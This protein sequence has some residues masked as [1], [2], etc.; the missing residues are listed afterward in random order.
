MQVERQLC[1]T[2]GLKS[3]NPRK[4]EVYNKLRRRISSMS[5]RQM[6]RQSMLTGPPCVRLRG[7]FCS[8]EAILEGHMDCFSSLPPREQGNLHPGPGQD[9]FRRRGVNKKGGNPKIL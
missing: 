3:I 1:K 7:N 5:Q 9:L 6:L 2:L 8:L 4:L